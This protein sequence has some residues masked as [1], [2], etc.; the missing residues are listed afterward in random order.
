MVISGEA[1]ERLED[2]NLTGRDVLLVVETGYEAYA[3]V[4]AQVV[5][6]AVGLAAVEQ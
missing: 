5:V 6:V 1:V 3:P 2:M 4:V